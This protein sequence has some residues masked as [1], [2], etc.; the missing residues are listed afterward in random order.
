MKWRFCSKLTVALGLSLAA[1]PTFSALTIYGLDQAGNFKTRSAGEFYIQAGSFASKANAHR[2]QSSLKHKSRYPVFLK[3]THNQ[4]IV[5]IGPMHSSSEVRTVAA[6]LGAKST[7]ARVARPELAMHSY[8]KIPKKIS[9]QNAPYKD[10]PAHASTVNSV[11]PHGWF[12][13]FGE[14]VTI[15]SGTDAVNF[16]TSGMPGF[17]DDKYVSHG[18][19]D[20]FAWSING[21]YQWQRD[22]EW[23][24]A[25]SLGLS[26]TRTIP[27]VKGVIY[28]N[29]LEDAKN[30]TYKYDVTQQLPMLTFKVDLCS[31][32]QLMPYISVGAGLAINQV[33]N[34]SDAPIPGATLWKRGYGFNSSQSTHFANSI[35]AGIDYW[36][37][38]KAQLSLGYQ[39][40]STGTINTGYGEG[41]LASNQL[42]NK[43]NTSSVGLQTI[44]FLD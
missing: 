10:M 2:Y 20:A 42:T 8:Q 18:G 34:Y 28:V 16:A 7:H 29:S 13:G 25:M 12:A 44:F 35:G 26:Y 23:F 27:G 11:P 33:H 30:F 17:P 41:V 39:Y 15:P 43:L 6:G 40:T 4:Y 19:D 3:Q 24:P 9:V 37:A 1:L 38:N 32:K 5:L 14:G 22:A 21:G 31:W 36:I